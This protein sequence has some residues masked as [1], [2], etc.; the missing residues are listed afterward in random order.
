MLWNW[1]RRKKQYFTGL[2]AHLT[3][4][5]IFKRTS[6]LQKK[7]QKGNRDCLFP[8]LL[9]RCMCQS[10]TPSLW[11]HR[12]SLECEVGDLCQMEALKV[13]E[14]RMIHDGEEALVL[15]ELNWH[16]AN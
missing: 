16:I 5:T 4:T 9:H 7:K 13:R 3:R 15:D 10:Y 11:A 1:R 6:P 8:R 12:W 2:L 14:K